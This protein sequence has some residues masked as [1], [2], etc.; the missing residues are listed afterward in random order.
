MNGLT[1][2]RVGSALGTIALV[3][4]TMLG[5]GCETLKQLPGFSSAA[6]AGGEETPAQR[7]LREDAEAYNRVMLGGAL[8]GAAIGAGIGAVTCLFKRDDQGRCVVQ[9]GLAGALIGGIA[10]AADGY[11]TAKRQQATQEKIREIELVTQD[12]RRDNEKIRSLIAASDRALVE[13]R[14]RARKIRSE[15]RAKKISTEQ[16]RAEHRRFEEQATM[17]KESLE[18]MKKSRA[19]YSQAAAKSK[20]SAAERRDYRAE[21][22][23]LDREIAALERNVT[24]MNSVLSV[25]RV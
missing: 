2:R 14:V 16:A 21:M 11:L 25:S 3:A 7:Q 10:G 6:G 18:N 15:L 8:T 17:M 9:R 5:A 20:A 19:I 13:S 12:V 4:A 24:A 22:G 23:K 1:P